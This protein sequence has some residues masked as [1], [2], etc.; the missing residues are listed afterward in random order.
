L[1]DSIVDQARGRLIALASLR[2]QLANGSSTK[3]PAAL[4]AEVAATIAAVQSYAAEV[5]S[6]ATN[7]QAQQQG[8]QAALMQATADARQAVRSASDDI[9]GRK[10]FDPYLRFASAEDEEAYRKREADRKAEIDHAMAEK[11]PQGTLRATDL[12]ID[13]LRDAGAHGAAR[14]PKYQPELDSLLKARGTLATQ[15]DASRGTKS[16]ARP[17][18]LDRDSPAELSPEI[19]AGLKNVGFSAADQGGQGHGV[20]QDSQPAISRGR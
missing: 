12:T 3:S 15:I 6:A 20:A 13:Q 7:S 18:A 9:F 19:L 11:T 1:P 2:D 17:D 10:I 8:S 4:R 5:R 14:S 16:A